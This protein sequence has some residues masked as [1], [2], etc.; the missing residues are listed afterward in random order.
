MG[1]TMHFGL[2]QLGSQLGAPA[3]VVASVLLLMGLAA[4]TVFVE[5]LLMLRRSRRESQAFAEQANQMLDAGKFAEVLA[6]TK[7]YPNG[8]L[9]R[10]VR[11]GL[12]TYRHALDTIDISGLS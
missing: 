6:E 11:T 9:P 12:A 10:I 8:T 1:E 5:R 7:K 4:V 2:T 3:I